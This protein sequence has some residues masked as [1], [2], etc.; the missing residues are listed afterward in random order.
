MGQFFMG[1][2]FGEKNCSRSESR[3]IVEGAA[4]VR[5]HVCLVGDLTGFGE[6][7]T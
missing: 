1:P 2:V 6:K 5:K 3:Q 4:Q 7:E